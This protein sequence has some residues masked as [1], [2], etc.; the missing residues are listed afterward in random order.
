MIEKKAVTAS[1]EHRG[2]RSDVMSARM[3]VAPGMSPPGTLDLALGDV[4][5]CNG[6]MLCQALCG[7]SSCP[8]AEIEEGRAARQRSHEVRDLA[9]AQLLPRHAQV[10]GVALADAVVP[11][12]HHL[13]VF[14]TIHCAQIIQA[15]P[16]G[17]VRALESLAH[18]EKEAMV[19]NTN[20]QDV[21]SGENI[22]ARILETSLAIPGAKVD[23]T[24]FLES[25]LSP[26]CGEEKVSNAI[27]FRPAPAGISPGLIDKLADA[28]TRSH[29][30]RASSASFVAGLPG[31]LAMV[32]T[33]PADLVQSYCH[34]LVLA[35]KLAYLY[36]WPDLLD[37]GEVDEHTKLEL[38]LMI[39]VMMG[40]TAAN[41]GLRE[42][43][44]RFAEQVAHRLPR[45]ALTKTAYYP[46]VKQV[47]KW[48]G[49][50]V[51][52]R[53][54]AGGVAKAIP[55]VSGFASAGITAITIR[56]MAKRL[57]NHL[58][59]TTYASPCEDGKLSQSP[60]T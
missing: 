55:V 17:R 16:A 30:L 56:T 10:L 25:Q 6:E 35:Q 44:L 59:Q 36:G 42:V 43:A 5:T 32:A 11:F 57:Q 27:Q 24:S 29:V 49:I 23:R 39:G 53:G 19:K 3:K 14:D 2:S 13:L 18:S 33:I 46:I 38:T 52:K 41:R 12:L 34:A 51:T 1:K 60:A 28:C 40:A 58:K 45:Q 9:G 8:A 54:F 20:P 50:S 7:G 31:G 37:K 15:T 48:I 47:G 22:W 26:Y 21:S 4:H